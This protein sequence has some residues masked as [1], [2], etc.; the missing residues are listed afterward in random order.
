MPAAGIES[1]QMVKKKFGLDLLTSGSVYAEVL[2][3]S[4]GLPSLVLIAPSPAW[5]NRQR[6]KQMKLNALSH[7][8]AYTAG[9]G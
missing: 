5:T 8:G 6:D 3:R 2:P 4:I 9:V 1:M 7:A